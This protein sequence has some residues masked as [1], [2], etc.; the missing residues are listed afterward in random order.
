MNVCHRRLHY[1]SKLLL[2]EQKYFLHSAQFY[3]FKF[4]WHF[5]SC[6]RKVSAIRV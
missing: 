3:K 5:A 6:F 4:T 2:H 1:E